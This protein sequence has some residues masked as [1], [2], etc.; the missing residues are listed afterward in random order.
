M[1][2]IYFV[3]TSVIDCAANT[4][5][6]D[7]CRAVRMFFGSAVLFRGLSRSRQ[8]CSLCSSRRLCIVKTIGHCLSEPVAFMPYR[9]VFFQVMQVTE[10]SYAV[11]VLDEVLPQELDANLWLSEE[12]DIPK[13]VNG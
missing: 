1:S 8:F 5:Q 6:N 12:N 13:C 9:F 4:F 3:R 11:L 10:T 2:I 7:I